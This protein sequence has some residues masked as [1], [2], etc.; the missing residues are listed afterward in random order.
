MITQWSNVIDPFLERVQ[1][2]P[3]RIAILTPDGAITYG[4]L[5]SAAI[6][7]AEQIS[8]VGVHVP[9]VVV[10]CKHKAEAVAA[11]LGT[12]IAG[13][14]V[15]P[16]HPG[17]T[18]SA[19]PIDVRR[20]G[21]VLISG[22]F[23]PHDVQF[24]LRVELCKAEAPKLAT[25]RAA[26]QQRGGA[27]TP[28][29]VLM[30]SGSTGRP[31]A[32]LQTQRGLAGNIALYVQSVEIKESDV[33]SFL[34]AFSVDA[35][36]MDIFAALVCGAT[37]AVWETKQLGVEGLY[38]WIRTARVSVLHGT[39]SVIELACRG[40]NDGKCAT[41]VTRV[42]FGGEPL[43]FARFEVIRPY[44]SRQTVFVNGLGPSECTVALQHQFSMDAR[45]VGPC[46]IGRPLP[47]VRAMVL[48]PSGH[49]VIPI[50][51]EAGELVIFSPFLALGYLDN[52]IQ[53]Q[54]RFRSFDD[55]MVG[56][57]TGDLVRIESDGVVVFCGR[58]DGTR[59]IAGVFIDTCEVQRQ[60]AELNIASWVDV[61]VKQST[62]DDPGTLIIA[63]KPTPGIFSCAEKIVAFVRER[64][65]N[66]PLISRVFELAE[67][68]LTESG[69]VDREKLEAS[70]D[71]MHGSFAPDFGLLGDLGVDVQ[72]ALTRFWCTTLGV[73]PSSKS[74]FYTDG[75]TS[76]LLMHLLAGLGRRMR[77][78]LVTPSVVARPI[79]E[80]ILHLCGQP[81]CGELQ[82][83]THLNPYVEAMRNHV[84][85]ADPAYS[86]ILVNCFRPPFSIDIQRLMLAFAAA[87]AVPVDWQV[88]APESDVKKGHLIWSRNALLSLYVVNATSVEGALSQIR[89]LV[90]AQD[91]LCAV[92]LV[93]RPGELE[94]R[95]LFAGSHIHLD[96]VGFQAL[97]AATSRLYVSNYA[98][99]SLEGNNAVNSTTPG[100]MVVDSGVSANWWGQS[101][102][103]YR[104]PLLP[105]ELAVPPAEG[106]SD[107]ATDLLHT[108]LGIDSKQLA[109][110]ASRH[111][112]TLVTLLLASWVLA[113]LRQTGEKEVCIGIPID[114]RARL[115]QFSVLDNYTNAVPARF[116][117]TQGQSLENFLSS[118]QSRLAI[119]LA[120]ADLPY[121]EIL[122]RLRELNNTYS[123]YRHRIIYSHLRD[124]NYS[125]PITVFGH[126]EP[127]HI[128]YS[129]C[130]LAI[131]V[132]EGSDGII[133]NLEHAPQYLSTKMAFK[134]QERAIT[135]LRDFI[136][137]PQDVLLSNIGCESVQ[138]APLAL[139]NGPR[140]NDSGVA[141]LYEAISHVVKRNPNQWAIIE[142]HA[143]FSYAKLLA[144]V[145]NACQRLHEAIGQHAGGLVFVQQEVGLA[146]VATCIA[147]NALG[148][149]FVP[150]NCD[151]ETKL[152]PEWKTRFG[153]IAIVDRVGVVNALRT[154]SHVNPTPTAMYGM[155]TSGSTGIPKLALNSWNGLR[156][157]FQWM[158]DMFELEAPITLQTTSHIYDSSLWQLFWPLMHGGTAVIP[159][160]SN[161][162]VDREDL[163]FAIQMEAVNIIDFVPSV[164]AAYMNTNASAQAF[165]QRA[166]SLRHVIIG[167]EAFSNKHAAMLQEVIPQALLWNL[168]GPTE[169]AI[170][171]VYHRYSE[172]STAPLPLGVPIQNTG[173]CIVDAGGQIVEAGQ[174]GEI[175]LFGDCVG[176][177]YQS[178]PEA[179]R[180]RFR[181]IGV[182]GKATNVYMT[183]DLGCVDAS[184]VLQYYG[185]L[186]RTI[187]ARGQWVDL[188]L[189]EQSVQKCQSVGRVHVFPRTSNQ[190]G[191]SLIVAAV[192]SKFPEKTVLSQLVALEPASARWIDTIFCFE[193]FPRSS[194]GKIDMQALEV[195]SAARLEIEHQESVNAG[196]KTIREDFL[197]EIRACWCR[198]LGVR[199]V[200]IDRPF[201][202][203]GGNSLLLLKLVDTLREEIHSSVK[204]IDI[205]RYPTIKALAAVLQQ[206]HQ[207]KLI[208]EEYPFA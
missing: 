29:Y 20:S 184:G 165:K 43:E 105:G 22:Q 157:R 8:A 145:D 195:A 57:V 92:V 175:A 2:N 35:G 169:A 40:R 142:P 122:S 143:R 39:P 6:T 65:P 94:S 33:L 200:A 52:E 28:A 146:Y 26:L 101:A 185:R 182:E 104:P 167:G 147:C 9:Y 30:T 206:R 156:N 140:V 160:R 76:L 173:A 37:L 126:R 73:Q 25:K 141:G 17:S 70:V 96:G 168:Y 87:V 187:K 50:Q 148:L 97:I 118:V 158:S 64:F 59:K 15:V 82:D 38:E 144:D 186:G 27:D 24:R 138:K 133:F 54:Q 62:Q 42:V 32:V 99:G 63:V 23:A 48:N 189:L 171:S 103:S 113:I 111:G 77:V 5:G 123:P 86:H 60:V 197:N 93:S 91:A 67:V 16:M 124:I 47:G 204:P 161:G 128:G 179:T 203:L 74:N 129:S 134:L 194:S 75:G 166:C 132:V 125:V 151:L 155:F 154:S 178:D 163:L 162:L 95:L 79:F 106:W 53:T 3:E 7:L 49:G 1:L 207:K 89:T 198:T 98:I 55:Q 136:G 159:P 100:V 115:G 164:L 119:C 10:V 11:Y 21:Y 58:S 137:Q 181:T 51:K 44:F 139:L 61:S 110:T 13:H 85:L 130:E 170:G 68:P 12:M 83:T 45:G 208:K 108:P 117:V 88:S 90:S 69:K 36:L 201:F 4:Q 41:D 14:C 190:T 116:V 112:V 46:P 127:V 19:L 131:N 120:F 172:A 202:D 81:D 78:R 66:M 191:M 196:A 199:S 84:R 176:L 205:F 34:P 56:Y 174:K 71:A 102:E 177:G 180:N 149:T 188:M 152:G 80:E 121:P 150:I 192:E 18:L 135:C 107:Q 72:Q 193:C 114:L 31:K 109:S 153:A 183:G